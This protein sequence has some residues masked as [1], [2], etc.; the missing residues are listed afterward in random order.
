[1]SDDASQTSSSDNNASLA[2]VAA[3]ILNAIGHTDS[4]PA[5]RRAPA[6]ESFLRC[7]RDQ[8][9]GFAKSLGLAGISKLS[10]TELATRLQTAFAGLAAK[11]DGV[12]NGGPQ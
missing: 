2:G 1:M 8:L 10:K 6:A 9:L 12:T 11:S 3:Q 4:G 5:T 7:T